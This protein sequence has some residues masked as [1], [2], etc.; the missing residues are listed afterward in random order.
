[1]LIT[2][3]K[4]SLIVEKKNAVRREDAQ[5]SQ[6]NCQSI[7]YITLDDQIIKTKFVG[8]WLI[9]DNYHNDISSGKNCPNENYHL[10]HII[11]NK[12]KLC[13]CLPNY[14]HGTNHLFQHLMRGMDTL[15]F[16]IISKMVENM[17]GLKSKKSK[18]N[19]I[20]TC[21]VLTIS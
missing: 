5:K 2:Q 11:C 3:G 14:A 4:W 9:V 15:R 1:M 16:R 17:Q 21:I 6:M 18:D 7:F 20:F 8:P 19:K 12:S 13:S 10:I